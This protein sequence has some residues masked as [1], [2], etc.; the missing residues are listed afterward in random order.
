MLHYNGLIKCLNNKV[1][2]DIL[3]DNNIISKSEYEEFKSELVM[4]N[5]FP[6][7]FYTEYCIELNKSEARKLFEDKNYEQ[8]M[9]E[10][11]AFINSMTG[12]NRPS[13]ILNITCFGCIYDEFLNVDSCY[14]SDKTYFS[15]NIDKSNSIYFNTKTHKFYNSKKEKIK[16]IV[17]F[18]DY[19]V[20]RVSYIYF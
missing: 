11:F 3:I 16:D 4:P 20:I 9:L 15:I 19:D 13:N 17:N 2:T 10:T 1:F 12:K 7:S 5:P 8:L 14:T 6:D 18:E